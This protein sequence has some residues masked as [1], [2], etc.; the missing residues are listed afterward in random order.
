MGWADVHFNLSGKNRWWMWLAPR[1]HPRLCSIG[2]P[3][4]KPQFGS[5]TRSEQEGLTTIVKAVLPAL[6]TYGAPYQSYVA[7]LHSDWPYVAPPEMFP[8]T[9]PSRPARPG[10]F[11]SLFGTGFGPTNPPVRSGE[12]FSGAAPL[13]D[14]GSLTIQIGGKQAGVQ[15]A[16][17]TGAGL[18][19]FNVVV[20]A[21]PAG[22]SRVVA[23]MNGKQ[24]NV[25]TWVPIVP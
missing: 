3:L 16:G 17:L 21:L 8:V 4:A 18:Y 20:P 14:P 2:L 19:Q 1:T 6:F 15:F 5:G 10:E 22:N 24:N 9:V 11:I 12:V 25:I 13:T 23:T 7:A